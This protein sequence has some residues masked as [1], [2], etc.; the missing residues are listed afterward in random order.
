MKELVII[1]G[2]G[3]TGKTC[4]SASF[5]HL[6]KEKKVLIDADVDAANLHLIIEPRSSKEFSY[7]SGVKA[8][9]DLD[10]CSQCGLC[11]ERCEFE[12]ISDD[13]VVNDIDCEG[14]GVCYEFCPEQAITLREEKAGRWFISKT[15]EGT[16]VHAR[17]NIGGENSGLLINQL[18]K[19]ASAEAE[20]ENASFILTDGPPGTGCPATS[21][22]TNSDS[23]LIVCEP[24]QSG[25]HD[26]KKAKD[27]ADFLKVPVM[28]MVNKY[29]L[30]PEITDQIEE[31]SKKSN[32]LFMGKVPYDDDFPKAIMNK[33]SPVQYS[34]GEGSKALKEIF[35]KVIQ[36]ITSA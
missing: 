26:M 31:Y 27:L 1:S 4:V 11:I 16:M 9:I 12:A 17:L 6:L 35:D 29:D 10:K 28:V 8:E 25:F 30:N 22:I 34:D 5:A 15:D 19:Q 20:N 14:C 3:G 23:V 24:T 33:T 7:S 36:N 21:S 18:R 32:A 13:F 2:K